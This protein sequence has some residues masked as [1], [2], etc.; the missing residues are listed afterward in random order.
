[1][2]V[3]QFISFR[4]LFSRERRLL[5]SVITIISVLG[6][7]LGVTALIT[8][9][10]VMDGFDEELINKLMGVFS[11]IEV[12]GNWRQP[13]QNYN[14]LIAKIEQ[15]CP[16]VVGAAPVISRQAL[17]QSRIGIESPKVGVELR[18]ID[19][20]REAN[21]TNIPRTIVM[22]KSAPGVRGII[23]GSQLAQRLGVG[24]GDTIYAITRLARTANGPFAKTVRLRVDGV[25]KSGLYEVDANFAY[26]DLKT[27]QN[28][29][30]IPDEVD[31]IHLRVKDPS[32][33]HAVKKKVKSLVGPMFF[34]RSWDEINPDF[35]K[36]L[37]LEKLAM[38]VIL[39][40]IIVV[41]AFN[42]IG[43]LIMITTR[44]TREIGIIKSMG[45]TNGCI[46][47]IFLFYGI[48]IGAIGIL[49]GLILGLTIC[50]ILTHYIHYGLP[51]AIYG[52]STL[53]VKVKP[54]TVLIIVVA[55]MIICSIA[56]ILPAWQA[57][58]LHPVE[59]LRYE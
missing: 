12:W 2:R 6:V 58:R 26:T 59:A 41:A 21:V 30:V 15:H 55:T 3:E 10:G 8:V 9:I 35:F 47:R 24:I 53:P 50:Y 38:F 32:N 36:A 51:E 17:L 14:E 46:M 23:L 29:F 7:A 20:R 33:V 11:H 57:S 22:G 37:R 27:M 56:S 44:K 39:L 18:G 45:A 42:I 48:F 52:I 49:L 25:F 1:M 40:L 31:L 16:E 5:V 13:I 54:L 34:L 43:T 4:Y 19:P 28:I